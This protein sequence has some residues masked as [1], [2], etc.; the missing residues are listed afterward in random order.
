VSPLVVGALAWSLRGAASDV[1]PTTITAGGEPCDGP[2][3]EARVRTYVSADR[4]AQASLVVDANLRR[5]ADGQWLLDLEID[6]GG[7]SSLRQLVAPHCET[8]LDAAAFVVAVAIDPSLAGTGTSPAEPPVPAPAVI[9]APAS[10]A[11]PPQ[12]AATGTTTDATTSSTTSAATPP[13]RRRRQLHGIVRAGDAP[14]QIA[15]AERD[16]DTDPDEQIECHHADE[17]GAHDHGLA[18]AKSEDA[19]DL[20]EVDQSRGGVD[21]EPAEAGHGERLEHR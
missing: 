18:K 1:A 6:K 19:S 5:S 2:S 9:P 4:Q 13:P 8:V 21:D 12:V 14:H 10:E 3:L 20:G 17:R 11:T 15:D 7:E 16:R